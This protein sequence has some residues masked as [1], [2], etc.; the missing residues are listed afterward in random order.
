MCSRVFLLNRDRFADGFFFMYLWIWLCVSGRY[1]IVG[2]KCWGHFNHYSDVVMSTMASQITSL[3][4]LFSTVYSD[5]NQRKIKALCYWLLW[6]DFTGDR[7]IPH[8]KGQLRGICFHLMMSAWERSFINMRHVEQHVLY[9][10]FDFPRNLIQTL[11]K[12]KLG[13]HPPQVEVDRLTAPCFLLYPTG[14]WVIQRWQLAYM[15]KM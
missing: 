14:G 8:T 2:G 11:A 7:W 13:I 4:I 1:G 12:E 5:A 3:V 9:T 15:T 6:G 10:N